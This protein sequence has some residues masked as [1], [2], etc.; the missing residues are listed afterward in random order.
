M[1]VAAA[2]AIAS[3]SL[4]RAQPDVYGIIESIRGVLLG[5][6]QAGIGDIFEHA[7]G[8]GDEMVVRLDDGRA[9]TIVHSGRLQFQPGERVIVLARGRF[10]AR[11]EHAL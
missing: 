1:L 11:V 5:T 6:P 4:A 10:G 3:V 8:S 9:L 7:I 2:T